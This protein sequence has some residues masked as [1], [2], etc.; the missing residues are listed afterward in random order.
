MKIRAPVRGPYSPSEPI[1]IV[2]ANDLLEQLKAFTID[3]GLPKTDMALFD[4]RCPYCGKNDRIRPLEHPDDLSQTITPEEMKTYNGLW[5]QFA[6]SEGSLGVCK[7]CQNPL[8]LNGN[9][10]VEALYQI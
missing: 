6:V 1:D 7:F 9:R 4:T 10:Q 2:N 8:R 3:H 5:K